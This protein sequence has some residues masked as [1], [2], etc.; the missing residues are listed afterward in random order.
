M[1]KCNRQIFTQHAPGA[2]PHVQWPW[3]KKLAE[4]WI[5]LWFGELPFAEKS[6]Q[7]GGSTTMQRAHGKYFDN[8]G[9]SDR[10]L[11]IL[12]EFN[13]ASWLSKLNMCNENLL[14]DI[15]L[16]PGVFLRPQKSVSVLNI[17]LLHLKQDP[18]GLTGGV[19]INN[20][21][22]E[23]LILNVTLNQCFSCFTFKWRKGQ[24]CRFFLKYVLK[25]WERKCFVSNS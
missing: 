16:L 11:P 21:K 13:D 20:I 7:I 4:L 17:P 25:C 18:A 6:M 24:I 9:R 22:W 14:P 1:I 2:E 8:Q 15:T 5:P 12:F 19:N 23:I 10:F 3:K